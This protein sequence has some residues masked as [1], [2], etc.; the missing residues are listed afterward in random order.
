MRPGTGP[1]RPTAAAEIR[2]LALG[3][4]H[5][6]RLDPDHRP[7]TG[8]LTSTKPPLRHG[9]STP[10]LWNPRPPARQPGHRH[11]PIIKSR[12]VQRLSRRP[13]PV[14]RPHE[15]SGLAKVSNCWLWHT[16]PKH[17]GK[18]SAVQ[19]NYRVIKASGHALAQL[20]SWLWSVIKFVGRAVGQLCL[21]LWGAIKPV[22]HA[23]RRVRPMVPALIV[24]VLAAATICG[25]LAALCRSKKSGCMA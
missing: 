24:A 13:G 20:C 6:H 16:W 15:S 12:T 10:A 7:A 8:T 18:M 1:R 19:L 3:R 5:R 21:W 25:G 14:L 4:G 9:R 17:R 2:R 22:G 11:T 23:M